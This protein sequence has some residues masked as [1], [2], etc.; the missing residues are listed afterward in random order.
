MEN[1]EILV[2][3]ELNEIEAVEGYDETEVSGG[4]LGKIVAGV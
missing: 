2:T 4:G 3:E 1:N